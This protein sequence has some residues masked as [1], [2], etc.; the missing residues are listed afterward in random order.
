MNGFLPPPRDLFKLG[1]VLS[2][3]ALAALG[4]GLGVSCVA[5][6]VAAHHQ[7]VAHRPAAAQRPTLAQRQAAAPPS[8]KPLPPQAD[9]FVK[10]EP[11]GSR[12]IRISGSLS[13]EV[14]VRDGRLEAVS[15]SARA[16]PTDAPVHFRGAVIDASAPPELRAAA[17]AFA[18]RY[19]RALAG[20]LDSLGVARASQVRP[21]LIFFPIKK[22]PRS[23]EF[24][25]PWEPSDPTHIRI[26]F[27]VLPARAVW[28]DSCAG[29]SFTQGWVQFVTHELTEWRLTTETPGTLLGDVSTAADNRL[30]AAATRTRHYTR[31]FR[32]GLSNVAAE[33]TA[34]ALG[35]P[36]DAG[37]PQP[38]RLLR[39]FG[40]GLLKWH[41]WNHNDAE[42]YQA[43][44]ALV[45]RIIARNPPGAMPAIMARMRRYKS[46]D[47][48]LLNAII[49]EV[50]GRPV[51]AYCAG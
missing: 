29:L 30:L 47:G 19:D 16:T 12:S 45:G 40:P 33:R 22:W 51:E 31:W 11:K 5:P 42:H 23:Y 9:C 25:A 28:S 26:P 18:A 49:R 36:V 38:E 39:K 4:L 24:K 21:L 14:I 27:P 32:E 46:V 1:F 2:F 15:A 8:A 35:L 10:I 41:L 43:A 34:R 7:A 17:L 50:T 20:T 37:D 6:P 13:S 44:T 48:A 3:L